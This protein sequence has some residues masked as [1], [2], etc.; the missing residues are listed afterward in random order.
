MISPNG[1]WIAYVSK[2]T[3]RPEVYVQRFPE[4]GF[5]QQISTDGGTDPTW[6]PDGRALFYLTRT[7][8]GGPDEMAVVTIDPGPPLSVGAPE[9]LFDHAPYQRRLAQGRQYDVDPDGQ[10]FLMML[11]AAAGDGGAVLRRQINV[12]LNWFEEL[13]AR[14]PVN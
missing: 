12:V 1:Q 7:L 13:N 5:R 3:G 11:D 9:V 8:G 6:S 2:E 14:V 4:L 10:R